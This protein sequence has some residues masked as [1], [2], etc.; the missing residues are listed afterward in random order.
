LAK[1][2]DI[3]PTGKEQ[4]PSLENRNDVPMIYF[5]RACLRRHEWN[6]AG[7]TGHPRS[8]PSFWW[9]RWR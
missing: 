4:A 7:R 5:D 1:P 3:D 8:G 2:P 6:R 9:F